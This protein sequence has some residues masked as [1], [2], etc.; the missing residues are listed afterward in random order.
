M[1]IHP[2]AALL[3]LLILACAL[4]FMIGRG[5]LGDEALRG[6]FLKIRATRTLAAFI[7]GAS[8]G[9]A[10]VLVQGLFRNPLASPDILGTTAGAVLFGNAALLGYE[11]L[12]I[13]A[14]GLVAPEL[15]LPIGAIFGSFAAL[16]VLIF[17]M[18]RSEDLLVLLL[19]GFI[20][21]SLFISISSFLMS[22]A[23][24]N[25]ELSRALLAFT[26]G[27][28]TGAS[29]LQLLLIIPLFIVG[30]NA[31]YFF[32]SSLDLLLSGEE[33]ARSL[34]VDIGRT[35]LLIA[36]WIAVLTGVAVSL[37]GTL[38]F[39]GLVVP[40]LLR[41]FFGIGHARLIPSAALAGGAF[42]VFADVLIRAIPSRTEIPLGVITGLVGAPVF[43]MILYA[44]YR[45]RGHG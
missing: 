27:S 1:R 7:A 11:L 37:S 41:P 43:L 29:P 26:L 17:L 44:M 8:L 18:R 40:H 21:S 45:E 10:G 32:G 15:L 3:A 33:E 22:V 36:L 23:Q 35:R 24:E 30:L 42:V 20:L 13:S 2:Y 19:T 16:L 12:G 38:G 39:V 25:W 4:S 28:V 9:V 6:V 14:L 31:S 34:G 5:D